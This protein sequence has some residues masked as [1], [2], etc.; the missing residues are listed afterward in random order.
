MQSCQLVGAN[1]CNKN[2]SPHF[3]AR[4]DH[5]EHEKTVVVG[6]PPNIHEWRSNSLFLRSILRQEFW[7]AALKG[8]DD[9]HSPLS[10]SFHPHPRPQYNSS[11]PKTNLN[12]EDLCCLVCRPCPLRCHERDLGRRCPCCGQ[13]CRW[14]CGRCCR[15]CSGWLLRPHLPEGESWLHLPWIKRHQE[16]KSRESN[17]TSCSKLPT[18]SPSTTHSPSAIYSPYATHSPS[19]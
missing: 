11:Q 6:S 13:C 17:T 18:H 4:R 5:I 15:W 14:Y 10:L 2:N 16:L 9:S 7:K 1:N 19:E 8:Q 3:P 12:H